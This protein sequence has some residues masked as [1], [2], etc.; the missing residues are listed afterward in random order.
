ML[1]EHLAHHQRHLAD[2]RERDVRLRVEVD[3][4]LVGMVGV[5]A[6]HRP[7]VPVDHAE[8]DPPH[9]V[10]GV[11]DHELAGGAT[12]GELDDRGLQPLGRV[13]GDALLEEGLA[14]NA[15]DP[16]LHHG[17]AL[18]QVHEHGLGALDVV[19]D[20]V[21]LG[22]AGLGKVEL[23]RTGDPQLL[24]RGLDRDVLLL[25]SHCL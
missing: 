25:L 12:A 19:A 10:G 14:G 24:A 8:V 21:E 20:Q 2:L 3:A 18:A 13:I 5:G 17:G 4:Q 16:A 15:V 23:G 1:L 22:E 9:E 11:V 6:A 7:G